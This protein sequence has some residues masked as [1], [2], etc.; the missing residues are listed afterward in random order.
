MGLSPRVRG[1]P[2]PTY[3]PFSMWRSIPARAGE[4]ADSYRY[5]ATVTVYPRACGGTWSG[6]AGPSG[7]SGLSPRVRGNR[8]PCP[9]RTRRRRS[10]P[11]R[12]GEPPGPRLD[13]FGRRSIPARAG[14]PDDAPFRVELRRVYPRACGGTGCPIPSVNRTAGLSPRVRGNHAHAV[15]NC[16]IDGSIPARAGEPAATR[17]DSGW[18]RVYPRACG[19]TSQAV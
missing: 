2:K 4:P 13:I 19:G 18:C 8:R 1:N 12:A 11:A 16:N 15:L 6:R 9:L 3:A 17:R 10:I 14:E 7:A 5:T